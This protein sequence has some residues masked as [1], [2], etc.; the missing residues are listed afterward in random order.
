[1]KLVRW[2]LARLFQDY[3]ARSRI[4]LYESLLR[5]ALDNGYKILSLREFLSDHESDNTKRNY[6]VL[7]LRH[8]IDSDIATAKRM[9]EIEASLKI[10]SSYYFR[11]V[12]ADRRAMN[13]IGSFGHEIGYHYEE[14]STL[15]KQKGITTHQELDEKISF[16]E[17]DFH[18]NYKWMQDKFAGL[19]KIV[20]A[21]GDFMN[22]KFGV[23][24]DFLLTNNS[25]RR[26]IG[27]VAEAYDMDVMNMFDV[28][29]SDGPPPQ[30]FKPHSPIVS[31]AKRDDV[32]LLVHPRSWHSS[33]R[34]N[35]A[36]NFR[37]IR[38]TFVYKV[39]VMCAR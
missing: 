37:R 16:A 12:T 14:I 29:I 26:R 25:L 33:I 7:V 20:A 6:P 23:S 21:H 13:Y 22:R 2:T 31:F 35:T 11:L 36:E 28:Y 8:D 5:D 10:K 15:I 34:G 38:D 39:R 3:L 9:A 19:S 32:Y 1:M 17:T 4:G 18:A 30:R 27:I 24:N